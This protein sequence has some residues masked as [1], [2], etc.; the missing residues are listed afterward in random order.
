MILSVC[1][2]NP[3]KLRDLQWLTQMGGSEW[4]MSTFL[5]LRAGV[6]RALARRL[7]SSRHSLVLSML[8]SGAQDLNEKIVI[9]GELLTELQGQALLLRLS[10]RVQNSFD[11]GKE[12]ITQV[13]RE[14]P[15][16]L[17]LWIDP[18]KIFNRIEIP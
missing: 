8:L 1:K 11:S 10:Q 2:P 5:G 15:A 6:R 12:L 14:L 4:E 9:A 13:R 7:Q 16:R 17:D 3:E 18:G